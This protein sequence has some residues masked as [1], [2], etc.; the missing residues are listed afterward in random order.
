MGKLDTLKK[1]IASLE[2]NKL[3]SEQ[4][5]EKFNSDFKDK[6]IVSVQKKSKNQIFINITY[7]KGFSLREYHDGTYVI[8]GKDEII[9]M[10]L[11]KRYPTAI[12]HRESNNTYTDDF[13]IRNN[14]GDEKI[15][16]SVEEFKA[17]KKN[18]TLITTS[19]IDDFLSDK[20]LIL[21]EQEENKANKRFEKDSEIIDILN[22]KLTDIE[23]FFLK[24][25][26]F[27]L[28]L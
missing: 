4:L 11:D 9:R 21:T 22:I 3:R 5:L 17:L 2:A 23:V 8:D 6:V 26:P 20:K 19:L 12:E 28:N 15:E 7:F 14:W 10:H 25:S 13:G 27:C 1:E 18:I 16:I 24:E